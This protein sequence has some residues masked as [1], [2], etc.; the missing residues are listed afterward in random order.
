MKAIEKKEY[1]QPGFAP[2]VDYG[3]W[4]VAVL[5]SC[6]ACT[7]EKLTRL[8]KH[9][10]TD[11]VFV[12]LKGECTLVLSDEAQPET[13]YGVKL[14]PGAAY[15]VRKGCWHNHF[16]APDSGV[17]VVENTGTTPENSPFTPMP[18]KVDP[19]TLHYEV[20]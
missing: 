12:L 16:L 11:E 9:D 19:E 3:A 6:P 7:P 13:I 18:C 10:L 20:L 4:R 15:N 2:L 5:N 17:L 8:Q 14:L 1:T